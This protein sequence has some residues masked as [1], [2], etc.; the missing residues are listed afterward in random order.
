[1]KPLWKTVWWVLRKLGIVLTEDLAI[2]LQGI[3]PK[4]ASTHNK[5]TYSTMFIAVL[6]IKA[7]SW[8]QPRCSPMQKWI[9]KMWFIYTMEC[10]SAIKKDD[11]INF[12]GKWM[13]LE[14]ITLHKVTQTQKNMHG[15][16]SLI[17]GY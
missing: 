6:F 10:D 7:Q 16:C 1:V 13:E 17:S 4:D 8:K 5:G 3:C 14:N 15:M 9:Q 12:S 11:F 2:P